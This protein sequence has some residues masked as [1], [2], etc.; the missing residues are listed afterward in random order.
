V[1]G[2]SIRAGNSIIGIFAAADGAHPAKPGCGGGKAKPI[3]T[4]FWG[5]KQEVSRP[6]LCP[7][8]V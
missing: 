2:V 4:P 5:E 3:T 8:S 1:S 7:Q 6:K